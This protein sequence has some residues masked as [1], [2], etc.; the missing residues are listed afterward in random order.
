MREA[1]CGEEGPYYKHDRVARGSRAGCLPSQ[2]VHF[3][4]IYNYL[5]FQQGTV[6]STPF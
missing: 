1:A 6:P 2:H 3:H 5:P 4:A